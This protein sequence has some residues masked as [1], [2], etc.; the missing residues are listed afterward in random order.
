MFADPRQNWFWLD[1][2]IGGMRGGRVIT[3][4]G[5]MLPGCAAGL[6]RRQ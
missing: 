2:A 4:P 6:G 1:D 3:D 5:G